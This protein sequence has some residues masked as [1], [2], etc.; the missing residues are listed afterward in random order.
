M[1]SLQLL[2]ALGCL[3]GCG[4]VAAQVDKYCQSVQQPPTV[5]YIIYPV[6]G[7]NETRNKINEDWIR[8][9]IGQ[10]ALLDSYISASEGLVWWYAR[11]NAA[12]AC[13]LMLNKE[14]VDI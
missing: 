2:L 12:Q 3:F 4:L 1:Y 8:R 13:V 5:S 14:E 6:N 7:M 9:E 10:D 11:M